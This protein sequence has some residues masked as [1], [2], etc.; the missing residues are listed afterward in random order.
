MRSALSRSRRSSWLATRRQVTPGQPDSIFGSASPPWGIRPL[1]HREARGETRVAVAPGA[2]SNRQG[3][4]SSRNDDARLAATGRYW[5]VKAVEREPFGSRRTTS[6]ARRR[7]APATSAGA[8]R[9]SRRTRSSVS[10]FLMPNALSVMSYS[11]LSASLGRSS[12]PRTVTQEA[13]RER[14]AASSVERPASSIDM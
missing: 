11:S 9:A 5:P 7:K 12:G 13:A 4:M 14:V 8:R 6:P 2:V 10:A 3:T 1:P